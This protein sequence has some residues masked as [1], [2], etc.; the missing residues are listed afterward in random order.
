MLITRVVTLRVERV[1][2]RGIHLVSVE[3]LPL[4]LL[5]QRMVSHQ[6]L[7]TWKLL[8]RRPRKRR[9]ALDVG[10]RKCVWV[11]SSLKMVSLT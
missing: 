2:D 10:D 4:C 6:V 1:V 7:S 11:S 5:G 9:T 3:T 8:E